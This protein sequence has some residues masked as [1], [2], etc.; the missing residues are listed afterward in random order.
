MKKSLTSLLVVVITVTL[1]AQNYAEAHLKVHQIST[2]VIIEQKNYEL[3]NTLFLELFEKWDYRFRDGLQTALFNRLCNMHG[4][5]GKDSIDIDFYLQKIV[6]TPL[7]KNEI[8]ETCR[9]ADDK[10]Q[11]II[12]QKINFYDSIAQSKLDKELISLIDSMFAED[13]RVRTNEVSREESWRVDSLNL[14]VLK[15]LMNKYGRFLGVR[16]LGKSA[17]KYEMLIIHLEPEQILDV[18]H[19]KILESVY[20]GDLSPS[21]MTYAIDYAIF[22]SFEIIDGRPAVRYSR[23]GQTNFGNLVVP[24]RDIEETNKLRKSVGLPPLEYRIKME[25][26]IYDVDIFKNRFQLIEE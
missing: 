4:T 2:N 26:L 12:S 10:T 18:W 5:W 25:N 3:A 20:R 11:T 23:Y 9:C 6:L 21:G 13:Q 19:D 17:R 1:S 16:D 7:T 14:V 22:K 15:E 24:V 8:L